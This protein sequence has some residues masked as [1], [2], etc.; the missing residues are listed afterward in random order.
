MVFPMLCVVLAAQPSQPAQPA[1]NASAG[2]P[3]TLALPGINAVNLA[4]GEGEMRAEQLAQKVT[5][6]GTRV[7]T[8]RDLSTVLGFERQRQLMGCTDGTD[9][10]CAVELMTAMGADG[11]LVGDL[12]RINGEYTLTLKVLSVLDGR[13]LA[14]HSDHASSDDEVEPMMD[15]TVFA[16]LTAVA[17]ATHRV[18]LRPRMPLPE[19]SAKPKLR[20]WALAPTVLGAVALGAGTLLQVLASNAYGAL[21]TQ[22]FS[23]QDASQLR[24]SGQAFETGGSWSLIGGGVALGVALLMYVVGGGLDAPPT[25]LFLPQGSASSFPVVGV[26][27]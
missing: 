27:P 9:S 24:A 1:E 19:P 21:M 13:V 3:F 22:R 7:I 26:W 23:V 6:Q 10:A 2:H 8:A 20:A 16:V 4:P 17:E 18:E 15:R 5:A 11:L 12:G 14:F 25:A